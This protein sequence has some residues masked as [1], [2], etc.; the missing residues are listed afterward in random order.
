MGPPSILASYVK[1]ER[2]SIFVNIW[3]IAETAAQSSRELALAVECGNK[4]AAV[5]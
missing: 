5:H 4:Q 1:V 2:I 3:W